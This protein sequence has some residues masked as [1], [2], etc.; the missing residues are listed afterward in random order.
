MSRSSVE[1]TEDTFA[2]LVYLCLSCVGLVV[3][4]RLGDQKTPKTVKIFCRD[5][6]VNC[7]EML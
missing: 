4:V 2:I 6:S 5:S 7:A 3:F 1:T